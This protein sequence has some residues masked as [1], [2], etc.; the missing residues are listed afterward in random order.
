M[1][2]MEEP[3]STAAST[4]GLEISP[5]TTGNFRWVICALLF[6]S[7]TIN[8]MDRQI[9]S[10][11]KPQLA[12]DLHWNE[13]DYA[14]IV[15]AFQFAYA[16][17]YLFGGRL[18]DWMGVK[19]GLPLAAFFWSV[20][21]AG[22]G[23]ARSVLGFSIARLGL[24]LAEGGN[25]PAAIKAVSQ[26]F[27]VKER[28]LATGLFNTGSN[29]GAI[30][31][32][33]TVPWLALR[34]GWPTAFY[35]TGALGLVWIGVWMLVYETPERQPRLADAERA[36]IEGGRAPITEPPALV[37]WVSL[38]RYRA[39]WAYMVAGVLAG[40][41]WWFYLFWIPDFLQKR[42][43]LTLAEIGAPVTVIYL[44]SIV[45]SISGGW[46]PARLISQ[47]MSLNSARKI[48]LLICALC[49]VPVFVASSV[50]SLVGLCVSGRPGRCRAPGLVSQSLYLCLR[51]HAQTGGEFCR[52]FRRPGFWNRGHV[53]GSSCRIRAG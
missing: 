52:R 7:T 27:P 25:F 37:P 46:L 48:A 39:V 38:L 43:H 5:A 45:S 35:I 10:L 24:G 30:V 1:A 6:F 47:G 2:H 51:H 28:A 12:H 41:V 23:L 15:T 9:I 17:G 13:H 11:L 36:Y 44:M 31:C 53:R 34:F 8:Y 16:L 22:H 33:L 21:C 14:N 3:K 32:P 18:M 20:A 42:F 19:R 50:S 4:L 40:P 49:V 26:W 29:I